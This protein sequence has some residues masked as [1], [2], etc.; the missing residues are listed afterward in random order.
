MANVIYTTVPGRMDKLL[1]KIVDVGTPS[2]VNEAWLKSLGFKSSN[3]HTLVR[4]LRA[5]EFVDDDNIPTAIWTDLR[6]HNRSAVLGQAMRKAYAHVFQIYPN[7]H[8]RTSEEIADVF[9]TSD[10]AVGKAVIDFAVSTFRSLCVLAALK[11]T[12]ET[13]GPILT[14]RPVLSQKPGADS[15]ATSLTLNVNIQLSLPET[16]NEDVYEKLFAALKKHLLDIEQ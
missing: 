4:V 7:A 6:G 9:K 12:P 16:D 8:E 11:D 15:R 2:K 13:T 10:R 3:D 14:P 5:L 1:S